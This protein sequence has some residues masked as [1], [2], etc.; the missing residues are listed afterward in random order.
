MDIIVETPWEDRALG[1][2]AFALNASCL[3]SLSEDILEDQIK[4]RIGKYG[5]IFVSARVPKKS[6]SAIPVLQACRFYVVEGV[7]S[8]VANLSDNPVLR[9]FLETPSRFLPRRFR[10]SDVQ[11]VSLD[12]CDA[13]K[14]RD[15]IVG[16][17]EQSFSDD[18]FHMDFRCPAGLASR[19]FAFWVGDL[20]QDEQVRFDLLLVNGEPGGFMARKKDKLV[21]A[22]FSKKYVRSGLGE[23]LW[24][25]SL[26]EMFDAGMQ[27][28]STLISLNNVPVLN[29]Y[30]R[31]GF[32]FRDVQYTFHCWRP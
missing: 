32:K 24:L 12:R 2:K 26:R 11:F 14:K 28:V 15:T 7:L 18:R 31:L 25:S 6:M 17:A 21:L 19:R 3:S 8:P 29:L 1:R 27:H 5:A 10:E 23:Y 4:G 13:N 22:G 30:S 16:M 20:L 9:A